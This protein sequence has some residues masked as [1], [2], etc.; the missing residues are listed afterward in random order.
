M[1]A[2]IGFFAKLKIPA[3]T[4]AQFVPTKV[5]KKLSSMGHL[6]PADIYKNM[7]THR[8]RRNHFETGYDDYRYYLNE[9]DPNKQERTSGLKSMAGM[10]LPSVDANE[11]DLY[12]K[13]GTSF[14]N[15]VK[16]VLD[17]NEGW[18]IDFVGHKRDWTSLKRIEIKRGK[19]HM[20]ITLWS[21]SGSAKVFS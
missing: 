11:W 7:E 2:H 8:D 6:T 1:P 14:D 19:G 12:L 5:G 13:P 16:T 10:Y 3:A 17:R 20:S 9:Y 21:C 4:I 15:A 18:T